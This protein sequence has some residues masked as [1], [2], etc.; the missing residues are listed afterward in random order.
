MASAGVGRISIAC[1]CTSMR[2]GIN[3]RPSPSIT[4]VP[5]STGI[6]LVEIRS[7]LLPRTSTLEDPESVELFPSKM[8]TFRKSVASFSAGGVRCASPEGK[9]ATSSAASIKIE[10]SKRPRTRDLAAPNRFLNRAYDLISLSPAFAVVRLQQLNAS[11][12]HTYR[13]RIGHASSKRG[14]DA[15]STSQHASGMPLGNLRLATGRIHGRLTLLT[16]SCSGPEA[17]LWEV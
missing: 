12:P 7:I 15:S 16:G 6:G 17:G 13:A 10:S 5:A 1:Q 3:V 4:R 11:A 2:P 14:W 9:R 8:R